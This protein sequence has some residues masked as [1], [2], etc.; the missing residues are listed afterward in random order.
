M[1]LAY[2]PSPA[3]AVW[4]VGLLPVRIQALFIVAGIILAI[5]L[6]ERRYRDAGGSPGVITDVAVWAIL[7]GLIPA[8]LAAFLAPAHGG[9]WQ[10][11]RTWDEALGYPGAATLGALAAW[12]ACR[13]MSGRWRFGQRRS[14]PGSPVP[15]SPGKPGNAA[16]Q[17]K[18]ARQARQARSARPTWVGKQFAKADRVRL[19][20][21]AGAVA[22]AMAFGYAVAELGSW[23]AQE[24]YG[25]PSSLWWAV[26]ISPAHRLSGYENFATF[27][28]VFLYQ[29]LW[30]V[31]TGIGLI[32]LTR[33]FTVTGDRAFAI[34]AAAYAAGGFAV[35]WLGIGHLPHVLGLRAG[36]L[37]DAVVLVGAVVYLAR[38]RR[39]RTSSLQIPHKSAMERDTPVM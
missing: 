26:N 2:I 15:G 6:A 23:A 24:G 5:V 30:A 17:A 12:A 39:R 38:T 21:V 27:Q 34:Q 36:E 29:A 35:F 14:R 3:R 18:R 37:G 25:R 13:R 28:P 16:R 32:W 22:P 8:A 7:A 20:D 33:R 4:H 1:P 19:A 11:V 9:F 10:G 31:T